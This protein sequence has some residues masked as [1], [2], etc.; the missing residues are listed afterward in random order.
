MKL[1]I[2]NTELAVILEALGKEKAYLN[3]QGHK[4]SAHKV[5]DIQS[6]LKNGE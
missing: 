5:S 1:E 6:K 2:T 4:E 3:S